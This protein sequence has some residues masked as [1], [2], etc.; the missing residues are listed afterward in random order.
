MQSF[1]VMIIN[2]ECA[3]ERR[4]ACC[5]ALQARGFDMDKVEIIA[6]TDQRS[7]P[8][9]DCFVDNAK[10]EGFPEFEPCLD[11]EGVSIKKDIPSVHQDYV[12]WGHRLSYCR[13]L[14]QISNQKSNVVLL[15]D[16]VWFRDVDAQDMEKVIQS[17]PMK[18]INIGFDNAYDLTNDQRKALHVEDLEPRLHLMKGMPNCQVITAV[19]YS[20]EGASLFLESYLKDVVNTIPEWVMRDGLHGMEGMFS[21]RFA[22]LGDFHWMCGP[23]VSHSQNLPV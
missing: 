13:A 11:M 20:P 10:F 16:D 3:I 15:E 6:G 17:Y 22:W 1:K 8:N 14:R 2:L 23:E 12:L 4:A 18:I 19:V 21:P 7:F 5:A 9:L